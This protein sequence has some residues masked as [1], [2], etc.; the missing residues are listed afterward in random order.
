M[1]AI[2]PPVDTVAPALE[3]CVIVK[4][5]GVGTAVTWNN[6]SSKSDALKPVPPGNVT[7]SNNTISPGSKLC[8]V[9][10]VIVQTGSLLVVAIVEELN[11]DFKGVISCNCPSK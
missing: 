10:V 6:L 3:L 9:E 5:V 2:L 8:D 7:L 1:T 11:V 4:V